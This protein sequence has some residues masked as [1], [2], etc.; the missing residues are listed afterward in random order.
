MDYKSLLFHE[1]DSLSPQIIKAADDIFDHP[2]AGLQETRAAS[3]LT[4]MFRSEGFQIETGTAGLP[5]A[6]RAV[7][8]N[9]GGVSVGLLCEYDALEGIGHACGHHLQGPSIFGAAAALKRVCGA[10]P[11]RLV[12]YG[13]PAEE[14]AGGKI[15]MKEKGCF[16]DIDV[17]FMMHPSPTTTTDVKCMALT[18]YRVGFHGVPAHAA[19]NPDK[20]RSALD[21]VMLMA[22]GIECLREHVL[23]DT[24][25]HYCILNGG[26]PS[27]VVPDY[28]SA[29]ICMRSYNTSYLYSVTERVQKIIQGAA[30][31]TETEAEI[32]EQPFFQAKIP[33]LSLNKILMDNAA[34]VGAPTIRPPREKTGSTDF[35][36]VMYDVP[37]SCIRVAFVPEGTASHSQEYLN[38]GKSA[39]AHECAILAA[40]ILAAS[41]YDLI[42]DAGR[43]DEVRGE[44]LR[45][46]AKL[47][48][49]F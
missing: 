12:V 38:A 46:K 49:E 11:F 45:N 22:H 21:A 32:S 33:V 28:A 41:A 31:M 1:V 14:T 40:K 25:L 37:G 20:G 48:K 35:G 4:E 3:E 23:D 29:E 44:F 30:M 5:T 9:G 42:S 34:A 16:K 24:R 6:F 27:N 15:A 2:E 19:I 26:G 10:L 13:T 18:T 8:D 47:E 7:Y 36:N 39:A 17:A 43:M